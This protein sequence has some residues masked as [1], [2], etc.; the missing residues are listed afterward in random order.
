MFGLLT[1]LL[2]GHQGIWERDGRRVR[3]RC[4][5]CLRVTPWRTFGTP[6]S[7]E[8]STARDAAADSGRNRARNE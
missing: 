6:A 2:K 8:I 1:C 4:L 7:A 3:L 5:R